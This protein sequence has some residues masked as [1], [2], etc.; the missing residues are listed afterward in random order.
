MGVGRGLKIKRG[1][2]E[3]ET[4]REGGDERW[5]GRERG[6]GDEDGGRGRRRCSSMT[7][8]IIIKEWRCV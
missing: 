2:E 6:R 8:I 1:E 4:V 7:V 3:G 5:G